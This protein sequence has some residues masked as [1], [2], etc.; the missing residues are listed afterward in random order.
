MGTY[1]QTA[2]TASGAQRGKGFDADVRG[3]GSRRGKRGIHQAES[4][5]GGQ[6]DGSENGRGRSR[7]HVLGRGRH[8]RREERNGEE[9]VEEVD[10]ARRRRRRQRRRRSD[11]ESQSHREGNEEED[12]RRFGSREKGEGIK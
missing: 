3:T 12:E 10:A 6:R 4:G 1:H 2:Q 8:F 7:H 5:N 11:E 9:V